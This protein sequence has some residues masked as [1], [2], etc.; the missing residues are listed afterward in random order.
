M[1]S[2]KEAQ[3][4]TEVQNRLNIMASKKQDTY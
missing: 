4:A 2:K 3:P 1:N